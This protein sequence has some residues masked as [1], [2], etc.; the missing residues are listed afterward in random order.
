MGYDSGETDN[1]W[2][3]R[4]CTWINMMS[5][6]LFGRILLIKRYLP[7][8]NNRFEGS[9]RNKINEISS[10]CDTLS[11]T[12]CALWAVNSA[13]EE[14]LCIRPSGFIIIGTGCY[15]LI[16]RLANVTV[17]SFSLVTGKSTISLAHMKSEFRKG[18]PANSLEIGSIWLFSGQLRSLTYHEVM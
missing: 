13:L 9:W 17:M 16:D 18:T 1:P 6:V 12:W 10:H 11:S 3:W 8:N 5:F 14:P 7:L 4:C 15:W 2:E